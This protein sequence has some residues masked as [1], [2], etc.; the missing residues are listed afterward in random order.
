MTQSQKIT[1]AGLHRKHTVDVRNFGCNITKTDIGHAIVFSV[2]E[3]KGDDLKGIAHYTI[4][5]RGS[6]S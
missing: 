5:K 4:S 6:I 2:T 3:G 1:I